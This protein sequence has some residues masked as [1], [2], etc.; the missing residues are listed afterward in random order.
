M[1]KRISLKKDAESV[2][3][4]YDAMKSYSIQED[5]L[6]SLMKDY[7]D[8]SN[9]N[10]VEVKVKLLNLFYSTGI[11]ATNAMTENI[12]SINDIDKRLA[13]GDIS[14]VEEIA[15]LKLKKSTRYNYSFATKYCAYHQPELYPIYDS[16]VADTLTSFFEKGLLPKHKLTSKRSV[17][18]KTLTKGEFAKKLKEYDFFV[19]VYRYFMEQYDLLDF[20]Y[21]QVD[22]YIWGAFKVGGKDFEIERMAQL[23][24]KSIIEYSSTNI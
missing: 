20:S 7:P 21:R 6:Q 8:H 2:L 15:T 22:S 5:L 10:A 19:A 9:K 3:K 23:N 13:K 4:A 18:D 14:L 12:L 11:Q 1:A 16:I 24:K 17:G